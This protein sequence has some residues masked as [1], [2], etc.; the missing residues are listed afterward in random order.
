MGPDDQERFTRCWTQVQPA[1]A[2]Y[3]AA[4]VPDPHA[5]DDV[6]QEVAV[7]LLRKFPEYD[8]A[9][10]FI[11]WAM[12]VAKMA[13]LSHR[14]DHARAAVR[15]G[16]EAIEA[17]AEAWQELLP[18][19]DLRRAALAECLRTIAGRARELLRLRYEEAVAPQDI[20]ARLGMTP[21][22]ARVA[23]VRVRAALQTCIERRLER[24]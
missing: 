8:A 5:A 6:V 3:V 21:V 17:L 4:L 10:P 14:R 19:A 9:R 22:A 16:P 18:E 15:F 7:A 12:G 11:A 20:A 24:A 2:G 1:I 13:I 23:L